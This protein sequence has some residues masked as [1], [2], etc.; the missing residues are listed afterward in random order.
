ME[1]LRNS[2][3][4][5][6]NNISGQQESVKP[7]FGSKIR[8]TVNAALITV[9]GAVGCS[10]YSDEG[11]Y[12]CLD[13]NGCMAEGEGGATG[14]TGGATGNTAGKAGY[15]GGNGGSWYDGGTPTNKDSGK[16]DCSDTGT[17]DTNIDSDTTDTGTDAD[18][19]TDTG[20]SDTGSDT[21]SD[22]GTDTGTPD[23]GTDSGTDSGMDSGTDKDAK[24]DAVPS[25]AEYNSCA[26][27]YLDGNS[28]PAQ[29]PV[30][31]NPSGIKE[32]VTY[33][34]TRCVDLTDDFRNCGACGHVCPNGQRCENASCV[35]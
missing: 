7:L 1:T 9:A 14:N 2:I 20:S 28:C 8:N 34:V 33:Q 5:A 12:Y 23:S 35:K 16:D 11:G 30:C 22:S 10:G 19:G 26:D 4:N 32:Q 3:D 21:G 15:E 24:I 31:C 18:A 17:T 25:P 13:P 27:Y 29:N 6:G